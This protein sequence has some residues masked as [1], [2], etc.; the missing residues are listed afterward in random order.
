MAPEHAHHGLERGADRLRAGGG[1]RI[2]TD[3]SGSLPCR[4]GKRRQASKRTVLLRSCSSGRHALWR[5]LFLSQYSFCTLDPRNLRDDYVDHW[6]QVVAHARI[7]F[8]HCIHNPKGHR[9][10]DVHGW[11]L[12]ASDGPRGYLVSCPENDHGVLSPTAALSSFPFLP[13]EAE[14]AL[15]SF[16]S[17][18]DGQLWSKYGFADAFAPG[19]NWISA[20]H[21]AINQGPIVATI[22]NYRSGLLWRLFMGAP[23]VQRGLDR[24]SFRD[25][26]ISG[27]PR[28]GFPAST[29]DAAF[30]I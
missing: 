27:L 6:Q 16:L 17:Y 10:Y 24:L 30:R 13:L 8:E 15:H 18:E 26:R 28:C 25:A 29:L 3:R 4:L 9:G 12:T 20:W 5:A 2:F 21:L 14:A 11:G 1:L 19:E 22:E 7:N 23:D